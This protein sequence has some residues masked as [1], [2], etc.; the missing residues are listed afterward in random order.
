M[1]ITFAASFVLVGCESEAARTLT[2]VAAGPATSPLS[3]MVFTVALAALALLFI[4]PLID[5]THGEWL[6][7]IIIV[8]LLLFYY[9]GAILSWVTRGQ[10]SEAAVVSFIAELLS[11]PAQW[12]SKAQN[13]IITHLPQA[14]IRIQDFEVFKFLRRADYQATVVPIAILV[15]G[16]LV[17]FA[18][19]R[20]VRNE[21]LRRITGEY[22][23]YV[24]AYLILAYFIS[25]ISNAS[26]LAVTLV[27][28]LLL[29]ALALGL[30]RLIVDALKGLF[31]LLWIGVKV[32]RIAVMAVVGAVTVISTFLK[33]FARK[34]KEVY[35][36]Y[37]VQPFRVLYS[38]IIARLNR[39][40]E[41][42]DQFLSRSP[43]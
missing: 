17:R 16:V 39:T 30:Y 38:R 43:K 6:T 4:L 31:H 13:F 19:T 24:V 27:F 23:L 21:R 8:L 33:D 18:I 15:T 3:L 29:I 12:L 1:G 9:A 25:A 2:R 40:E 7:S 36:K 35:E 42:L 11:H 32:L 37:L 14:D 10:D 5:S 28:L 34:M 22:W 26:F 20:Y 41:R